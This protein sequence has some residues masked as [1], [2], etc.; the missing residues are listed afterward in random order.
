MGTGIILSDYQ[1]T[2]IVK[3]DLAISIQNP[4]VTNRKPCAKEWEL[5]SSQLDKETYLYKK[6]NVELIYNKRCQRISIYHPL[7]I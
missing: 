6:R 4:L 3:R 7:I 1:I 5:Y 2:E